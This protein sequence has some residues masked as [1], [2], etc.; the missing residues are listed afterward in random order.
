MLVT[1]DKLNKNNNQLESYSLIISEA[2]DEIPKKGNYILEFDFEE[3]D[4]LYFIHP[5]FIV[6]VLNLYEKLQEYKK[7]SIFISLNINKLKENVQ[8]QILTY[9]TQYIDCSIV[10]VINIKQ[11]KQTQLPLSKL[12]SLDRMILIYSTVNENNL[13]LLE[14]K[15]YNFLP[16]IKIAN[17][18]FFDKDS[19]GND[20]FIEKEYWISDRNNKNSTNFKA[21]KVSNFDN[22]KMVYKNLLLENIVNGAYKDKSS[23][24]WKDIFE[25]YL[26]FTESGT[27]ITKKFQDIFR[28]IVENIEKHVK[29]SN[30]YIAF[31]KDTHYRDHNQFEFIIADDYYDG[32]LNK[33]LYSMKNELETE[34]GNAKAIS[35]YTEII[36]D[37]ENENY[38]K[39]LQNIFDLN[40]VLSAQRDR[41]T[42]HFG[43][44][45]LLKIIVELEKLSE[46]K[47][48]KD[49]V[50]L[51]VYLNKD[52]YSFLIEYKQGKA[53]VKQ[54]RNNVVRGTYIHLSFPEKLFLCNP[55]KSNTLPMKVAYKQYHELF[56]DLNMI[57]DTFY[58]FQYYLS[59]EN[60]KNKISPRKNIESVVI[61]YSEVK[62]IS[63]FLRY[64]YSYAFLYSLKDILVV[65]CPIDEELEYLSTFCETS[66]IRTISNIVFLDYC[67]PQALFIGG[68]NNNEMILINQ[69]LSNKYNYNNRKFFPSVTYDNNILIDSNLFYCKR[70]KQIFIPFELFLKHP[71]KS[72]EYLYTN[73]IDNFLNLKANFEDIHLNLK[74][75]YHT[76]KFFYLRSIFENSQWVKM[77]AFNFARK[78]REKYD[79]L[80]NIVF[81]GIEK[82]SLTLLSEIEYILQKDLVIYIVNNLDNEKIVSKFDDFVKENNHKHFIFITPTIFEKTISLTKKIKSFDEYCAIKLIS[83]MI[84]KENWISLYNKEIDSFISNSSDC[85]L[86]SDNLYPLYEIDVDKYN[87]KNLHYDN[88]LVKNNSSNIT[89]TNFSNVSWVD[90]IYFSHVVRNE[91]HFLFYIRS[92][93]FLKNNKFEIIRYLYNIKSKIESDK[94]PMIFAP[95]HDTNIEFINLV[96]KYI[97]DNNAIIHAVGL[98]SKEQVYYLKNNLINAYGKNIMEFDLYF[99][100]DVISSGKSLKYIHS[101][102]SSITSKKFKGIFTLIDR[103][104]EINTNILEKLYEKSYIFKRIYNSPVNLRFEDCYICKQKMLYQKISKNSFSI[105]NKLYFS[106]KSKFLIKKDAIEIEYEKLSQIE[107]LRNYLGMSS[108]E[109]IYKNSNSFESIELINLNIEK[110]Y[111]EVKNYFEKNYLKSSLISFEIEKFLIYETRKRFIQNLIFSK[112]YLI[113]NIKQVVHEYIHKEVRYLIDKFSNESNIEKSLFK[114]ILSSEDFIKLEK[115]KEIKNLIAYYR[116][117]SLIFL[118]YYGFMLTLS[119]EIGLNYILS[120]K[121]IIFYYELDAKIKKILPSE[122][123]MRF[124]NAYFHNVKQITSNSKVQSKYFDSQFESFCKNIPLKYNRNFFKIFAL[125]LENTNFLNI[126]NIVFNFNTDILSE[127]INFFQKKLEDILF[128]GVKNVR[129]DKLCFDINNSMKYP[130]IDILNNYKD[131]DNNG[132]EVLLYKGATVKT[133]K[134]N[135]K[136]DMEYST[137]NTNIMCD[138]YKD[139]KSYIRLTNNNLEPFGI[140]VIEH[141]NLE[142]HEHDQLLTHLKL[143]RK[144]FALQNIVYDLLYKEDLLNDIRGEYNNL[145]INKKK[146]KNYEK[147][148]SNI[149]HSSF[150]KIKIHGR[151]SNLIKK[152]EIGALNM[153]EMINELKSIKDFSIIIEYVASLGKYFDEN[154]KI[155]KVQEYGIEKIFFHEGDNSDFHKKIISFLSIKDMNPLIIHNSIRKIDINKNICQF[156]KVQIKEELLKLVFFEFVF[157][158]LKHGKPDLVIEIYYREGKIIIKNEKNISQNNSPES[159]KVGHRSIHNILKSDNICMKKILDDPIYYIIELSKENK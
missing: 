76:N 126:N 131:V 120:Y 14:N 155:E 97:F 148:I 123:Y 153:E 10:E 43:L 106:K 50:S 100:D 116:K 114:P 157:N 144:V 51:K 69:E 137:E 65:N 143:S 85:E 58:K 66:D 2:L 56:D 154:A 98:K 73:M 107:D 83:R 17:N 147:I 19:M 49:Y 91:N 70:N 55:S 77:I 121:A 24:V 115:I 63:D 23:R 61:N 156:G 6:L 151:L 138:F 92:I 15:C 38:V 81:V 27:Y 5:L 44:P 39:V 54:L 101:I 136:I 145:D 16:I 37:I 45:L 96:N 119:G 20:K 67:Y 109:Y 93:Q 150:S 72:E 36:H 89:I 117:K 79:T 90:S 22:R 128:L 108:Y 8:Y 133:T 21:R 25:T 111:L 35:G 29:G 129:I 60:L 99:I 30:G 31:Y 139:S 80:D 34:I 46:E 113:K 18:S 112:V 134:L 64:L 12:A 71:Y 7:Q 32:F 82:Y 122:N 9:L 105:S 103:S 53:I 130:L 11:S 118:D 33:Y 141:L 140:I 110:Y 68:K 149:N 74:N 75:G 152:H 48:N 4:N 125:Y 52:E 94:T 104:T 3:N 40:Y 47:Y 62:G 78:I 26:K 142:Q 42:K 84:S 102:L 13:T 86:C 146:Q 57:E 124:I 158:A 1:Y 95:Y 135:D 88:N 59:F 41:I 28:E 159:Y 87:I 132:Y 127:K